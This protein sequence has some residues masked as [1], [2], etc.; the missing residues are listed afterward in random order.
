MRS[1]T[2]PGRLARKAPTLAVPRE[3]R[4]VPASPSEFSRFP[5][6]GIKIRARRD[7]AENRLIGFGTDPILVFLVRDSLVPDRYTYQA[8][9]TSASKR[10]PSS[11]ESGNARKCLAHR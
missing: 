5:K 11:R 1:G 2:N 7:M 8:K 10:Q 4:G 9:H 3:A 6:T